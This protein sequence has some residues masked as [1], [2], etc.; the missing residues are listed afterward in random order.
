LSGKPRPNDRS[1]L[2]WWIALTLVMAVVKCFS[3]WNVEEPARFPD[4]ETYEA[5]AAA[6][7][8][9]DGFWL[10]NRPITVPLIYKAT[11]YNLK[12]VCWVQAAFASL[13]W[14][15]LTV[16]VFALARR[17][18]LGALLSI[19]VFGFALS[20]PV[21]GWDFVLLSESTS[22]SFMALMIAVVLSFSERLCRGHG[23]MRW[24]WL[25]PAVALLWSGTRDTTLYSLAPLVLLLV[26]SVLVLQIGKLPAPEAKNPLLVCALLCA[27]VFAAQYACHSQAGRWRTPLLNVILKRILPESHHYQEW[28]SRYGFPRSERLESFAGKK[29]WHLVK[30]KQDIF[31][32]VYW[33]T[34][35]EEPDLQAVQRWLMTRGISSYR[36][37]LIDRLPESALEPYR[38]I[39]ST[40]NRKS[41]LYFEPLEGIR[42]PPGPEIFYFKLPN[43]LPSWLQW[44]HGLA[45]VLVLVARRG[46]SF[47]AWT[48]ALVLVNAVIQLI[49]SYHGDAVE[50]GRHSHAA[51]L[52]FRLS[53]GFTTAAVL[54]FLTSSRPRPRSPADAGALALPRKAPVVSA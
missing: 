41:T 24:A 18:T 53:L 38:W 39:T 36:H 11:G 8:F 31:Q 1:Q 2:T 29:A 3:F 10:G 37:W 40:I 13:S 50:V 12:A 9:S 45:L 46:R 42:F 48:A 16:V 52:L 26:A 19:S 4:T 22:L 49:V 14:S 44:A 27:A 54:D 6:P 43:P 32:R 51:Y 7:L 34:A 47:L 17:K 15:A 20:P 33:S 21:H 23:S 30:G 35:E 28:Q 5:V 25:L